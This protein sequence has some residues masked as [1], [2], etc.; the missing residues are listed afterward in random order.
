MENLSLN[1]PHLSVLGNNIE[2]FHK[3]DI[4][5]F[6]ELLKDNRTFGPNNRVILRFNRI[7]S[8]WNYEFLTPSE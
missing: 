1:L 7:N 5:L 4:Y 3:D 6:P 2:I 8:S